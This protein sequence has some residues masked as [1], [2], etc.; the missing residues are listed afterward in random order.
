M[1]NVTVAALAAAGLAMAAGSASATE[2]WDQH[3]RGVESGLAAG[4]L[5]PEGL[6]FILNNY[7]A[8]FKQYG[9]ADGK[10]GMKLDAVVEVPILLWNTG[11]KVLGAEYGVAIAQPIDYT[12]IGIAN[13]PNIGDNGHW[14]RFNTYLVPVILSWA[15][16]YDLHIKGSFG[17]WL[18][19]ASSSPGHGPSRGGV[20]SGNG[21][22][23]FEP[24]LGISWLHDGWNISAQAY[25]DTST[26]ND[27]TNYQ[28]GDQIAVDY[29]ATKTIDNWTVGLGA[30]QLN[31]IQR[32]KR[33]GVSLSGSVSQSYGLGPIVGYDFGPVSLQATYNHYLL[34]HND[35]GDNVLNVRAVVPL[36]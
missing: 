32:D 4:A 21:F 36:F 27:R 7:V 9:P 23:T 11:V 19:N 14:G 10:S 29:T 3:L 26:K 33:N 30:F 12:R 35:V 6:Y 18:D 20:G 22:T 24:G 17:V 31:Q 16:P 2:L 25:Y 8:A 15:L 5:P 1:K 13:N 34:I 28:S